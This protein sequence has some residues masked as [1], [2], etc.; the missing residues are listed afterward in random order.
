[1]AGRSE[2]NKSHTNKF[3]WQSAKEAKMMAGKKP[4]NGSRRRRQDTHSKVTGKPF[5]R[6][7][8]S[9]RNH[10]PRPKRETYQ[11]CVVE[12]IN[13]NFMD[14]WRT[15]EEVAFESTKRVPRH[16]KQISSFVLGQIMRPIIAQ[17][18]VVKRK[19]TQ[20]TTVYRRHKLIK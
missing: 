5:K 1:M 6:Q 12:V 2:E 20:N 8:R 3:W 15:T 13:S 16:W 11:R 18:Y 19:D 17:G 4:R 7:D 14:D 10:G 9:V